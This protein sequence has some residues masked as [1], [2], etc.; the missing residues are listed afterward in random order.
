MKQKTAQ[1]NPTLK[2]HEAWEAFKNPL[3]TDILYGGAAG[4]GKSYWACQVA[5][6]CC[7]ELPGATIGIARKKFTTLM[8]TTYGT[9]VKVFTDFGLSKDE[10][11][12]RGQ[13][14]NDITFK[15]GSKIYL[16][17]VAYQPSDPNFDGL[18][19]LE[20]THAFG[21]EI[22]EWNKKAWEVLQT[23]IGRNNIF[24]INGKAI[25]VVGKFVGTCNPTQNWVKSVYVDPIRRGENPPY[26]MF[27]PALAT[28]NNYLPESY[29]KQLEN[30]EDPI[31][32]RRLLHGDWDYEDQEGVLMKTEYI[33][34]IFT[35]TIKKQ[36]NDK[37]IVLDPA[38]MGE[39]RAVFNFFDGLESYRI[40]EFEKIKGN[41]LLQRMKDFALEERVPYS[42]IIVDQGGGYGNSVIDFMPGVVAFVGNSSPIDTK[43]M[44]RTQAPGIVDGSI[45]RLSFK[46][47]KDQCG[48]KLAEVVNDHALACT[49]RV[50]QEGLVQEFTQIK[51]YKPDE[52][53]KLQILPKKIVKENI[54]RSPDVSDTFLMRMWF[55][56]R[57]DVNARDM[58]ASRAI[59]TP[60][61]AS[62]HIRQKPRHI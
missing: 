61:V 23:R 2:Q 11:T 18:G 10:W 49:A 24:S 45:N 35:N 14:Y 37:Y 55:E 28:D 5:T 41:E 6:V 7:L 21:E 46:S 50:D 38:H 47:L 13:P 51:S 4:G 52:E 26:R 56:L 19:G 34:D 53:G 43:R 57:K 3:I 36:P 20:L 29:I 58:Y 22:A 59:N 31:T 17:D 40:E 39:D 54:G 33:R 42:H 32:K 30:I 1:I 25:S 16:L 8:K 9:L 44:L 15:N 12:F 62:K 48:F 27:I 60:P